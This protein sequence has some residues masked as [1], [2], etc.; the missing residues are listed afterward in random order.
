[1]IEY[2]F[3]RKTVFSGVSTQRRESCQK[4]IF[5]CFHQWLPCAEITT[6]IETHLTC[7]ITMFVKLKSCASSHAL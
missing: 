2:N 6:F 7:S 4:Q 3:I 1:M 5:M